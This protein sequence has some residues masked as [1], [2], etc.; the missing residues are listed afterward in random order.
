MEI[1]NFLNEQY[2]DSA[3]YMTYRNISSYID[4]LKNSGRKAV[5]ICKKQNIKSQIKV[6]ALG[7]KIVE[8]AVIF[9]PI[10]LFKVVL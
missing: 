9:M 7:S 10:L 5:Y 6:S 4:G 2:S 1:T 3:L 8:G